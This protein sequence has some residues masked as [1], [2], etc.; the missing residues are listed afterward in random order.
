MF[1]RS[2]DEETSAHSVPG[3]VLVF[4]DAQGERTSFH[5]SSSSSPCSSSRSHRPST[6]SYSARRSALVNSR[7]FWRK[8]FAS[9]RQRFLCAST[10]V[11][12]VVARALS[13][14][15]TSAV[16]SMKVSP[17]AAGTSS[18]GWSVVDE[19]IVG[20]EEQD[21]RMQRERESKQNSGL[22]ALRKL[23]GPVQR[24][25]RRRPDVCYRRGAPAPSSRRLAGTQTQ[26]T[27]GTAQRTARSSS[28]SLAPRSA[29]A[30]LS[31]CSR[32]RTRFSH[33]RD[34]GRTSPG[35]S[36]AAS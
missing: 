4:V 34:G 12:A 17:V 19:L 33:Q 21:E 32:S 10:A 14:S 20:G 28:P 23:R 27:P 15:Q 25:R 29:S 16:C 11:C 18:E 9:S 30:R 5:S 13:H 26:R 2:A 36:G 7:L 1:C 3:R 31:A 24:A 8:C 6:T 22:R 35:A